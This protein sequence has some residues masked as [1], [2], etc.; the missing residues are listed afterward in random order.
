MILINLLAQ[1]DVFNDRPSSLFKIIVLGLYVLPAHILLK[2][3]LSG[4]VYVD[5]ITGKL[6][7]EDELRVAKLIVLLLGIRLYCGQLSISILDNNTL[8]P[9]L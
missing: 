1:L 3:K 9:S 4:M 5:V 2:I 6:F 8:S 7:K